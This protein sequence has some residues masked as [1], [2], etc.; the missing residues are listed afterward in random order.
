M[1]EIFARD[2]IYELRDAVAALYAERSNPVLSHIVMSH[3]LDRAEL[4]SKG[5][6]AR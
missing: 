1:G 3:I 6:E 2:T 4:E 5:R